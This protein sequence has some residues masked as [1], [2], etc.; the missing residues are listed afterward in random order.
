MTVSTNPDAPTFRLAAGAPPASPQSPSQPLRATELTRA[1]FGSALRR[2]STWMTAGLAGA[3][4]A[5]WSHFAMR[6]AA[7]AP[8]VTNPSATPMTDL[9]WTVLAPVALCLVAVALGTSFA[10]GRGLESVGRRA[11]KAGGHAKVL[12]ALLVSCALPV[13]VAVLFGGVGGVLSVMLGLPGLLP[14][15]N[16]AALVTLLIGLCAIALAAPI[17]MGEPRSVLAA[18]TASMRR[19]RGHRATILACLLLSGLASSVGL[20]VIAILKASARPAPFDWQA[21]IIYGCGSLMVAGLGIATTW[22][23]LARIHKATS[24]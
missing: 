1:A 8:P 19:T 10:V 12:A 7:L 24:P 15:V 21:H 6:S 9:F 17:A 22:G 3:P 11:P 18:F 5:A 4:F 20:Y 13:A 16:M 2:P 23:A 14:A